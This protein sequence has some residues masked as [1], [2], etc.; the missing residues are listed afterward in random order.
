MEK[1]VS[2]V[3]GIGAES[4]FELAAVWDLSP[5]PFQPVSD[6]QSLNVIPL[7]LNLGSVLQT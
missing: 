6:K 4:F 7:A 2:H 5:V 3:P 1:T